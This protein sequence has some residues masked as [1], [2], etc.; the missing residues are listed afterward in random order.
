MEEAHA[1]KHRCLKSI[2]VT[3]LR[4]VPVV[5]QLVDMRQP[6]P[7]NG[8]PPP[9]AGQP[10]AFG[11]QVPAQTGYAPGPPATL[12]QSLPPSLPQVPAY[13]QGPGYQQGSQSLPPQA[14]QPGPGYQPGA[15]SLPPQAF[16]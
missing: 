4:S 2:K 7:T 11:G 9:A 14:F 8:G 13:Q 3:P 16:Q 15:Q 10:P 12:P 1:L 5:D 6:P